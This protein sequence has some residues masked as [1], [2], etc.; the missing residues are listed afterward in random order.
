MAVS[1]SRPLVPSIRRMLA[2]LQAGDATDDELLRRFAEERDEVAFEAILHRYGRMV[3]DVCRS[4]LA[5]H[6][7]AEDAFQ[8]TFLVLAAKAGTLRRSEALASWL[9][10]IA[11]RIALKARAG[12]ARRREREARVPPREVADA[13]Q[14]GWAEVR[15]ILH[16]ELGCLSARYRAPLGLCYLQGKTQDEAAGILGLSKGTL[17]RRLE[18]GRALLRER[19]VRRGLGPAAALLAAWPAA[20]ASA[21]VPPVLEQS[22]V[23]AAVGFATGSTATVSPAVVTLTEGVL[24]VMA[25]KTAKFVTVM[26][27]GF[28]ALVSL[29]VRATLP[30]PTAPVTHAATHAAP[31]PKQETDPVKL[32]LARLQGTWLRVG[33]EH[34]G[35]KFAAEDLKTSGAVWEIKGEQITWRN[36]KNKDGFQTALK[37]NPSKQVKEIDFGPIHVNG[38]LQDN[39]LENPWANRPS[40]GIYELKGDTLRVCYGAGGEDGKQ[41]PKEFKTVP[42]FPGRFPDPH[43]VI[44]VFE[45]VKEKGEGK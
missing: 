12:S 32:E 30:A 16:E 17:K 36:A 25:T 10:G 6:A 42:G 8:A 9:H 3:L 27:C 21:C 41:R 14:L 22:T 20:T 35:E 19:L 1:S 33:G 38:K 13:D 45:R 7:D 23:K 44:L 43:E 29:A 37:I 18:C 26:A 5:G 11:Y 28:L 15:A 4:I 39:P 31:V 34:C 2:D 24:N 40:L